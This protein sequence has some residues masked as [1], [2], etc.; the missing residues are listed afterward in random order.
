MNNKKKTW[1]EVKSCCVKNCPQ[2][3][4][5]GLLLV[6]VKKL[7]LRNINIEC[8]LGTDHTLFILNCQPCMEMKRPLFCDMQWLRLNMVSMI[9]VYAHV[10]Y[11]VWVKKK[12]DLLPVPSSRPDMAPFLS[13]SVVI[14]WQLFAHTLSLLLKDQ[15]VT[16]RVPSQFKLILI[17]AL[18]GLL[19]I[20]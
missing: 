7:F 8:Y 15:S 1:L 13:A 11:T 12:K 10:I 19:A 5:C 18:P 9:V 2:F 3:W 16:G 20:L 14:P 17:R 6:L 4:A